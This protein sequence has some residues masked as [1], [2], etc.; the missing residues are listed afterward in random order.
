M[1]RDQDQCSN[2]KCPGPALLITISQKENPHL[3]SLEH[4]PLGIPLWMH[5]RA[6]L[7]NNQIPPNDTIITKPY[8]RKLQTQA[9]FFF[10]FWEA[11][12][13]KFILPTRLPKHIAKRCAYRV[14][15]IT[16]LG[17]FRLNFTM[18]HSYLYRG[19]KISAVTIHRRHQVRR[20]LLLR[21]SSPL[22]LLLS[23]T[24]LILVI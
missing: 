7:Y 20:R 17:L 4:F 3:I 18:N 5:F 10:F 24:L 13:Y 21:S 23:T 15:L 14:L 9:E 19:T 22:F 1:F 2:G 12:F 11:I 8:N 6:K 16:D